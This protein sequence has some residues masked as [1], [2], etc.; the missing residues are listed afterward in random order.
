MTRYAV[1]IVGL[2]SCSKPGEHKAA[3]PLPL[4]KLGISIDL[5]GKTAII[6]ETYGNGYELRNPV[7]GGGGALHVAV[8]QNPPSPDGQKEDRE[9]SGFKNVVMTK[10]A[11][12]WT[13]TGERPD[14]TMGA[15]FFIVSYRDVGTKHTECR[16][17]GILSAA[18]HEAAVAAC[19]SLSTTR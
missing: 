15:S 14:A 10:A 8:L 7:L 4:P 12:G 3:P 16:S 17:T 13:M 6:D 18:A 11:D 2:V 5:T 1:L 9:A 19:T